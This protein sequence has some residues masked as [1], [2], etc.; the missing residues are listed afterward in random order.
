[1]HLFVSLRIC[2]L[3]FAGLALDDSNPILG[4][5]FTPQWSGGCGS[6]RSLVANN[7]QQHFVLTQVYGVKIIIFLLATEEPHQFQIVNIK[8][9]SAYDGG[10]TI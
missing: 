8:H 4:P 9:F 1:M 3:T 2:V 6:T 7:V 5:N 10:S